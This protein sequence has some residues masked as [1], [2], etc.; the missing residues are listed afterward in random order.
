MLGYFLPSLLTFGRIF[1]GE[2]RIWLLMLI[3]R[4]DVKPRFHLP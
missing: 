2:A 3:C 4:W 1:P